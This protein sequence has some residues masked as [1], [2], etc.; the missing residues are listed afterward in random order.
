MSGVTRIR[1][2]W[3]AAVALALLFG[4]ASLG[5]AAETKK[6]AAK[7]KKATPP[8]T[9]VGKVEA[10][11]G[12]KGKV[13][14]I[15][16]TAADG[17][18][19]LVV[20]DGTGKKMGKAGAGKTVEATGKTLVKGQKKKAKNWIKVAKFTLKEEAPPPAPD[21]E[22]MPEGDDMPEDVDE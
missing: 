3:L 19:Y 15:K 12:K 8:V 13:L 11:T 14:S 10:K 21:E 20:L 1:V 22:P 4:L 9:V 17:K 6:K 7:K 5:A 16:V 2:R 18:E